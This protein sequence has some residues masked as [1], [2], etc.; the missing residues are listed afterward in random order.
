MEKLFVC[1]SLD[2]L[3]QVAN[4]ILENFSQYRVFAFYG[5]MGVGKTTLIKHICKIL[6]V[7]DNVVSP[8]FSI[9]NE[10]KTLSKES[11]FHFDFYRIKNLVEALDIGYEDYFYSDSFCFI[12][13]PEKIEEL[14][15]ENFVYVHIDINENDNSRIIKLKD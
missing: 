1:K 4:L 15:P 3:S 13:W 7:E 5:K 9:I 2:E 10:Y 14:L 11:V 6:D 12:E 8:S